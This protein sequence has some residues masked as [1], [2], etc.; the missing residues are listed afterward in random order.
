MLADEELLIEIEDV[1]PIVAHHI[2]TFFQQPH[3][4]QVIERLADSGV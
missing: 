1:G 4:Q 2:V 3:N